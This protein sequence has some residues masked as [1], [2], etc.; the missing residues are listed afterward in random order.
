MSC[1]PA[2]SRRSAGTRSP[3]AG[4]R[5]AR[6]RS[7]RSGAP[8]PA[9]RSL[10]GGAPRAGDGA[11]RV[12]DVGADHPRDRAAV[13][14]HREPP[15]PDGLL[16][17]HRGRRPGG[18]PSRCR[19]VRSAQAAA[20][21]LVVVSARAARRPLPSATHGGRTV[22]VGAPPRGRMTHRD[23]RRWCA[24]RS[25]RPDRPSSIPCALDTEVRRDLMQLRGDLPFEGTL[26][27]GGHSC[28][29]LQFLP[30][31]L[32]VP[33]E[34]LQS[35]VGERVLHQLLEH[36]ERHRRDVGARERRLDDVHR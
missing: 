2:G 26:I 4:C 7:A 17:G 3:R 1:C 20:E 18:R 29:F 21:S 30:E 13:V 6:S 34:L 5:A 24:R 16:G 15:C 19:G 8:P 28:S 9:S 23:A 10:A 14:R 27:G 33:E 25:C 31:G 11:P 32:P 22:L 35:C 36:R 12:T